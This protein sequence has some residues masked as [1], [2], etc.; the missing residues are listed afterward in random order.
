MQYKS[1]I[2]ALEEA[3]HSNLQAYD[4]KTIE[5][6]AEKC[7]KLLKISKRKKMQELNKK[8]PS[9]LQKPVNYYQNFIIE[10]LIIIFFFIKF[11]LFFH[12]INIFIENKYY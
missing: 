3:F 4:S 7:T 9:K 10:R 6:K 2:K 11:F 8:I 1:N 5:K 12:T